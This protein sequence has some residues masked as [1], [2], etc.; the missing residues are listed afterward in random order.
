MTTIVKVLRTDA[1]DCNNEIE[2]CSLIPLSFHP[3]SLNRHRGEEPAAF[4]WNFV[5]EESAK[6]RQENPFF[7]P[8]VHV[9]LQREYSTCTTNLVVILSY[10][11]LA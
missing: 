10:S 6:F 7:Y 8:S 3:N 1:K 5:A 4:I 2:C 9:L 11:S